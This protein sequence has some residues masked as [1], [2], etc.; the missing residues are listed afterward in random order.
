MAEHDMADKIYEAVA[1]A[2]NTGRLRKGVD[3]TTKAIERGTAKL[4]VGAADVAPPELLMHLPVLCTEKHIPYVTV[5]AKV[6][7]GKAAGINVPTSAVAISEEGE[8]KRLVAEIAAKLS[9]K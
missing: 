7:L 8:A 3:E 5:P 1:V 2:H 6:E 4:V 9:A